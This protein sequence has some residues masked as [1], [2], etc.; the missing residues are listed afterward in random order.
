MSI[1]RP[2]TILNRPNS[3]PV[4]KALSQHPDLQIVKKRS[5]V[6][7]VTRHGLS[8]VQA[9]KLLGIPLTTVM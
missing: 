8:A 7:L 4:Q 6:Q 2:L 9:K 1:Q 3:H 5:Y